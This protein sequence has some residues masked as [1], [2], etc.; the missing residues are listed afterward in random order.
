MW[1]LTATVLAICTPTVCNV[2]LILC[3]AGV[4]LVDAASPGSDLIKL[5][6]VNP[7]TVT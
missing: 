5:N 4:N 2:S 3:V 7:R 1:N 6:R